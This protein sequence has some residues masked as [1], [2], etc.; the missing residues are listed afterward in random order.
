M[1]KSWR[2][3][4]LSAQRYGAE[5]APPTPGVYIRPVGLPLRRHG[6]E[7]EQ[8]E[9]NSKPMGAKEPWGRAQALTALR[10]AAQAPCM[11]SW[12]I[13]R[14]MTMGLG[15]ITIRLRALPFHKHVAIAWLSRGNSSLAMAYTSVR[16]AALLQKLLCPSCI[17]VTMAAIMLKRPL[18]RPGNRHSAGSFQTPETQPWRTHHFNDARWKRSNAQLRSTRQPTCSQVSHLQAKHRNVLGRPGRP[19]LVFKAWPVLQMLATGS[20]S[21]SSIPVVPPYY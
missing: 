1:T 14:T 6:L 12:C 11:N 19:M 16:C 3:R 9:R 2:S 8:P 21:A 4:Q 15:C 17:R 13:I 7:A 10:K 20:L 18:L 5:V